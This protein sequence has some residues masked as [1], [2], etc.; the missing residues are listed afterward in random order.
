MKKIVSI[1][2]VLVLLMQCL[3]IVPFAEA[4]N[5]NVETDSEKHK[6]IVSVV[7]DDSTSMVQNDEGEEDYT[8]L[9]AEA[10][11]AVRALAAMMDEG[12]ELCFYSLS[13]DVYQDVQITDS[14]NCFQKLYDELDEI[15]F[16]EQTHFDTVETAVND[17]ISKLKKDSEAEGYLV[18]I[19]DGNFFE[20]GEQ[21]TQEQLNEKFQFSQVDSKED[22][23]WLS[24]IQIK[25][26]LIKELEDKVLPTETNQLKVYDYADCGKDV[27]KLI[28]DV[29]NDI[30]GRIDMSE[31]AKKDEKLFNLE[32]GTLTINFD[33]PVTKTTVFLQSKGTEE[34]Y[35]QDVQRNDST[36]LEPESGSAQVT[37][38]TFQGRNKKPV[39]SEKKFDESQ[40]KYIDLSG[41]VLNYDSEDCASGTIIISGLA[42]D[43]SAE[44]IEV[45]YEAAVQQIITVQVEDRDSVGLAE[46]KDQNGQAEIMGI[47]GDITITE[48]YADLNGDLLDNPDSLLLKREEGVGVFLDNVSLQAKGNN[49]GGGYIY[50]DRLTETDNE[51]T[52]T[53]TNSI[54][55]P[56]QEIK[57]PKV[58]PP[59]MKLEVQLVS[60]TKLILDKDGATALAIRITDTSEKPVEITE[61]VWKNRIT[62]NCKSGSFTTVEKE[63]CTFND[64]GTI[65]IPLQLSDINQHKLSSDTFTVTVEMDYEEEDQRESASGYGKFDCSITSGSHVLSAE[66]EDNAVIP[67]SQL[68][69][70]GN[71]QLP[72]VFFC[73]GVPLRQDQLDDLIISN[74]TVLPQSD[75]VDYRAESETVVLYGGSVLNPLGILNWAFWGKESY[76]VTVLASYDKWN[77]PLKDEPVELTVKLELPT[78]YDRILVCLIVLGCSLV[79]AYFVRII[80]LDF[81][82]KNRISLLTKFQFESS[83]RMCGKII[84]K[85]TFFSML[86]YYINPVLR[87]RWIHIRARWSGDL[88][89]NIDLYLTKIGKNKYK[90]CS[91]IGIVSHQNEPEDQLSMVT[92]EF[93]PEEL[94]LT[95]Y[96]EKY[97][98]SVR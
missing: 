18:V 80:Y 21:L 37:P 26:V 27:T 53:V 48:W 78:I 43:I 73:D 44:N 34:F 67:I 92:G 32:D 24:Q 2:V 9:W 30:Y 90:F 25:Y 74:Y 10:D 59:N 5:A 98:F 23:S 12:D 65:T 39:S 51:Q 64:D 89:K 33:I 94:I 36:E 20:N 86:V 81:V 72:V 42:D 88:D 82:H 4:S 38:I 6:K 93:S 50:T 22:R 97:T 13:G 75:L 71:V 58:L 60:G 62:L 41:A 96:G 85:K 28:A 57:I 52:I 77:N 68:L 15:D 14:E 35:N 17:L 61:T 16:K 69:F 76:T 56:N 45:Y 55:L 87:W 29:I 91:E 1:V 66:L 63:A 49:G 19:T 11:Y 40:I 3:M 79:L 54:G 83:N 70:S 31:N 95:R 84:L 46:L 47:E 7:F 8:T